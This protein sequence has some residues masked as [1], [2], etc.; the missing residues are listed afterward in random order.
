MKHREKCILYDCPYEA[1]WKMYFIW[2]STWSIVKNVFCMIVH[3]VYHNI[4]KLF[5]TWKKASI[6]SKKKKGLLR[7]LPSSPTISSAIT[8]SPSARVSHSFAKWRINNDC[9]IDYRSAKSTVVG[10]VT[11]KII[12]IISCGFS[13]WT[14][15]CCQI[16]LI[17][18]THLI[19]RIAPA[20]SHAAIHRTM[21]I[22]T[23]SIGTTPFFWIFPC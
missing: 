6:K 8:I 19:G 17:R 11:S 2:L 3:M 18:L 20:C 16:R 5:I 1:S 21:S 10:S 7:K 14:I 15:I 23:D 13:R 12:V 4:C 9:F 22:F